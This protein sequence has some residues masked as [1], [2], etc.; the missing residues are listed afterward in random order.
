MQ[1]LA[2]RDFG[3]YVHVPYCQVRCGYCDFNTYT[4][5]ELGSGASQASF[6]DTAVAELRLLAAA[7]PTRPV[8]HTV[9]FGGGTPT[10]LP[11][12]DLVKILAAIQELFG[13]VPNA[14]ITTEANPDSV[15]LPGLEQL[16]AGGFTRISIGMQSAVE[17]V[18]ATLD[19]THDPQRLPLVARWARDAGFSQVSVDLIY[20][21]PGETV[22]DWRHTLQTA[23]SLDPDHISAY[24]LIVEPGTALA[25]RVNRGELPAPDGDDQATKYELADQLFEQAGLNW[26]E[27][28]N[29]ARSPQARC[30]HNLLYWTSQNWLGV[31]PGAHSHIGGSRWWNR[32]HPL[33]YAL[34]VEK[35]QLPVAASETVDARGLVLERVLLELRLQQGIKLSQ[36]P[37]LQLVPQV[38]ET[39]LAA[40]DQDRLILT[41]RGRLL[42]DTVTHTLLAGVD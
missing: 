23:L 29:W 28:S 17:G 5:A 18:L 12:S 36:L 42:A 41:R 19:R 4:A 32:K 31:G 34:M 22:T 6:A 2:E 21:T 24:A 35:G 3:I 9:F 37:D 20:G 33:P 39:G 16:V 11:A 8:A 25:R 15:D 40:V 14:E 7:L 10:L 1:T 27:I 26:Y 13:L 30:R 38:V